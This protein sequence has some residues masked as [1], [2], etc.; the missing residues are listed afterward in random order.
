MDFIN[1]IKT[2]LTDFA[3]AIANDIRE[4]NTKADSLKPIVKNNGEQPP[5]QGDYVGQI[6]VLN[7]GPTSKPSYWSGT[8]WVEF[9]APLDTT[10]VTRLANSE[11]LKYHIMGTNEKGHR[12]QNGKG[13]VAVGA[14]W[15][16]VATARIEMRDMQNNWVSP[17]RAYQGAGVPSAANYVGCIYQDTQTKKFYIYNGESWIGLIPEGGGGAVNTDDFITREELNTTLK[18]IEDEIAKLRG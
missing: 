17:M 2:L 3:K 9:D 7:N 14:L 16:N 5:T 12:P 1:R 4:I 8:N 11:V 6:V 13:S 10:Q 15:E 18:K